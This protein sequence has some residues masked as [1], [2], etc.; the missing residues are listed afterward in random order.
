MDQNRR[1]SPYVWIPA[2]I[3]LYS[4]T[5]ITNSLSEGIDAYT[6]SIKRENYQQYI[7]KNNS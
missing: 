6:S 7:Q 4:T 1:F 2:A 3:I 5:I